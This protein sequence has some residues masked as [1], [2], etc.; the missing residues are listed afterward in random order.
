[1]YRDGYKLRGG[2][3]EQDIV[4]RLRNEIDKLESQ[5]ERL[6]IE[7]TPHKFSLMKTYKTMI[8]SRQELLQ[9]MQNF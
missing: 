9:Q 1:M 5:L 3:C 8:A 2:S 7:D 6:Q 4:K